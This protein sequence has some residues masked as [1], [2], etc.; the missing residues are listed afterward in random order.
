MLVTDRDLELI[1]VKPSIAKSRSELLD[2]ICV[3]QEN[4]ALAA[5]DMLKLRYNSKIKKI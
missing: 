2:D 5:E 3:E 4:A 1:G